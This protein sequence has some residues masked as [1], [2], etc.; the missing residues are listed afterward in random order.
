MLQHY[1]IQHPNKDLDSLVRLTQ[2]LTQKG[3]LHIT[4]DGFDQLATLVADEYEKQH[5]KGYT[6]VEYELGGNDD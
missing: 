6:E 2:E 3:Q 5:A 1:E 4:K